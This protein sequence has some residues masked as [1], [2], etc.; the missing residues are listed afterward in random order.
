MWRR[1]GL[2]LV[3]AAIV[4]AV[5]ACT[6]SGDKAGGGSS[7]PT[8]VLTLESE[9]DVQQSGAPEFARAVARLSGGSMRIELVKA[10]R[11]TE[12]DFERGVVEDVRRGKAQL[13]IVGARVWDTLGVKSFRAL[14]APFLVDSLELQMRVLSS[15]LRDRMLDGV[16]QAGVVGIAVL[17]GPL[18]RPYGLSR[19]FVGPN[20][21]RDAT[22]GI[23]PAGV[24][25]ATFRALGGRARANASGDL[26]GLNGIELDPATL[27]YNGFDQQPGWL[28]T[29]VVLWPKPYSIVMNRR[30]FDALP[31]RQQELLRR[32]GR[33]AA[34]P[35]ERQTARDAAAALA[36]A[37]T[38]AKLTFVEA[39]PRELAALRAAV[40]PVYDELRRDRVTAQMLS[41]I[42]G[43]RGNESHVA[44]EDRR[45]R[46][47][48]AKVASS[49][50][51]EGTW[52]LSRGTKQ[53]LI[54]AGIDPKNA[55]ALSRLGTP[56]L[57]FEP[58]GRHKGIDLET[59]KVLSTGTYEVE[60][61]VVRLVF[62]SGV[63]VQFGRVYSLRWSVYRDSLTFTAI[64]GSEPLIALVL[65]PWK[66]VR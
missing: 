49:S 59:G 46:R 63:A 24:A 51:L 66:R 37:C 39:S 10:G 28:T 29:N 1:A 15:S 23:R 20:D 3:A 57:V 43:L 34:A 30:A 55:E 16:E 4:A 18:R 62:E 38:A 27:V 13:G 21:S 42:A 19:A 61:D 6:G 36:Q 2:A 65:T 33:E 17:P 31:E 58:G 14:L 54:E 40:Q 41:E 47:V 44:T 7:G 45:C 25:R 52:K 60:G 5:T 56:T 35:E 50:P 26:S 53:D 9:D 32:A 64:P 11:S 12:I 22:I 8:L 48:G